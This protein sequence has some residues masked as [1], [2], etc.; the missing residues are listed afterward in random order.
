[1][2]ISN[3]WFPSQQ[4]YYNATFCTCQGILQCVISKRVVLQRVA[5]GRDAY[6]EKRTMIGC[7]QLACIIYAV[8]GVDRR[9]RVVAEPVQVMHISHD[10]H[11]VPLVY[12]A[13]DL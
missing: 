11:R 12:V 5:T 7:Q 4:E 1:M 10:V 13:V 8:P 3:D 9:H 6:C 2:R